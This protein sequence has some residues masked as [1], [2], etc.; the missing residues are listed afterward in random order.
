MST[1]FFRGGLVKGA[2]LSVFHFCITFCW[3]DSTLYGFVFSLEVG[4]RLAADSHNCDGSPT[5][6]KLITS[7]V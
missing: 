4:L 2:L 5:V 1:A 7:V 6:G 3:R